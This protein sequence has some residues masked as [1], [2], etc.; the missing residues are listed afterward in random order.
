MFFVQIRYLEQVIQKLYGNVLKTLNQNV[1]VI[2]TFKKQKIVKKYEHN[3]RP[4]IAKIEAKN[5][6]YKMKEIIKTSE[7]S[8]QAVLE[9]IFEEIPN[10]TILLTKKTTIKYL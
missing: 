7:L 5:T 8:T 1:V 6:I 10:Y 4:N 3:H 2:Y 9:T